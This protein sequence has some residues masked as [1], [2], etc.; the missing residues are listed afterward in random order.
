MTTATEV[1]MIHPQPS[2]TSVHQELEEP[3]E[4]SPLK[5]AGRNVTLQ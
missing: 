1:G 3:E 2:N 5:S 4:G